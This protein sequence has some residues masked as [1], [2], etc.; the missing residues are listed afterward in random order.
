MSWK[1]FYCGK[2]IEDISEVKCTKCGKKVLTK[3]R[4]PIVQEVKTD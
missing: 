1:C 4:A 3:E 2:E